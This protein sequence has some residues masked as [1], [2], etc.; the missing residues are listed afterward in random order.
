MNSS[1]PSNLLLSIC[2]PTYNF[3]KFIGQTLDSIL[4]QLSTEV[5]I[6]VLDGGS[7][8]ETF[9]EVAVRQHDYAQLTY[10]QQGFRGGI[11]RDIEKVVS[12]ARG[13]YC[14]LFSADD[15]MLPGAVNKVLDA[16]KSNH[17]I[18]LCEHVLCSLEMQPMRAYPPFNKMSHF[19][20]FNLGD[21]S[22]REEYFRLARTSE[23]FFSFLSGPIFKK[24]VWDA[25][26][27]IP[28]SF[29]NSCWIVAVH[30][31]S[32]IPRGITLYYLNEIL[33]HKRGDND[34]FMEKGMVNRYGIAINGYRKIS[35]TIFGHDSFEA[36]HIRRSICNDLTLKHLLNVKLDCVNR[37][38]YEDKIALDHL[39]AILYS[40]PKLSN[41]INL[42]IYKTAP[43]F[44][45][46]YVKMLKEQLK[47]WNI[48]GK[49]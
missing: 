39:V 11:D 33:I 14:W 7:K 31:L 35:D 40:D 28:E 8:D 47:K 23:A 36:F 4:S 41:S 29:R 30:L 44:V 19:G 18:Y 10:Y 16:I 32:M 43:M 2:I 20:L 17:D 9:D 49:H 24:E 1:T 38:L 21:A 37:K 12:L 25:A 46:R 15:V 13:K 22:Q 5:E 27:N 42:L 6:I 26:T 45:Y 48:N 34:S 3:G